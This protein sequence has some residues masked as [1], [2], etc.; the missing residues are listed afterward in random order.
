M[1]FAPPDSTFSLYS[2]DIGYLHTYPVL[3]IGLT[4]LLNTGQPRIPSLTIPN[5][6]VHFFATPLNMQFNALQTIGFSYF[7]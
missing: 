4:L 2:I 6:K 1:F 7:A 3:G 5:Y